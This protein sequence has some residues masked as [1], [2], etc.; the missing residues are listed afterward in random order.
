MRRRRISASFAFSLRYG[1][2][3]ALVESVD[4][5]R[6][7]TAYAKLYPLFQKAYEELGFPGHYFNDRLVEVIDVLLKTPERSGPLR[8]ELTE[9]KSGPSLPAWTR[10][11]FI[12]PELE[13]L[14]AGQ[15][16]LLRSGLSNERR[17]KAKLTDIRRRLTGAALAQ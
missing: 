5:G 9:V 14:S 1:P 10:Y 6:A 17:L 3:V 12:D 2:F 7:V 15:K 13:S 4:T 16:M 8:V 11:R